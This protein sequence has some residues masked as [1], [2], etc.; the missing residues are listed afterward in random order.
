[1]APYPCYKR[2]VFILIYLSNYIHCTMRTHVFIYYLCAIT[3]TPCSIFCGAFP[4]Q[5]RETNRVHE[6]CNFQLFDLQKK[7]GIS[8]KTRNSRPYGQ[9]RSGLKRKELEYSPTPSNRVADFK[10][11]VK[12]VIL[13][14]CK[15][16]EGGVVFFFELV[17]N[18][19]NRAGFE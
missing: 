4:D 12:R 2:C 9:H 19:H 10:M 15:R 17:C 16:C 18:G 3:N 14:M 6:R 5:P 11:C 1:M 7:F 8:S 13:K